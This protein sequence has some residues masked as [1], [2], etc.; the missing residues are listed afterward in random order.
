M[1]QYPNYPYGPNPND[2]AANRGPV[3]GSNVPDTGSTP[4]ANPYDPY[5]QTIPGS[6]AGYNPYTPLPPGPPPAPAP[7]PPRF[8]LAKILGVV[9]LVLLVVL[10][11]V[12]A[13]VVIP[14]QNAQTNNAHATATAQAHSNATAQ[15]QAQATAISATA[16]VSANAT[17][18]TVASHYPFSSRL[19][20]DDPLYDN[21]HGNQWDESANG[22]GGRCQFTEGTYRASNGQAG[23]FYSCFAEKTAFSNFTYEV[24]MKIIK[25][26]AGALLFRADVANSK[27]YYLE[28]R[29][30]GY[31][32]CDLFT[33][34]SG[35]YQTLASGSIPSAISGY[36]TGL[37]Q[38]NVLGVVAQG[39]TLQFYANGQRFAQVTDSTYSHG[40]IGVAGEDDTNS[41]DVAYTDARVWTL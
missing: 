18:T 24:K 32:E 7:S 5:G 1:N 12:I 26:D 37:N 19:V 35:H 39:S 30:D 22:T 27:Y 6:N 21:S 17:A 20:L 34:S 31:Y 25:G 13:G 4:P 40:A 10:G 33:D 3:Y 23:Y 29:Q 8:S 11:G 28:V 9:G 16:T 36:Y 2:P 14:S 38:N 41:T 15:A